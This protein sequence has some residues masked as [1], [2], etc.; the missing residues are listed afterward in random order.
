MKKSFL[1][2]LAFL[3]MLSANAQDKEVKYSY[4]F[5]TAINHE[6]PATST[7]SSYGTQ[8]N[9]LELNGVGNAKTTLYAYTDGTYKI[10]AWCGVEGYDLDFTLAEDSTITV[11]NENAEYKESKGYWKVPTGLETYDRIQIFAKKENTDGGLRSKICVSETQAT[12]T[13]RYNSYVWEKGNT[14]NASVMAAYYGRG[15][16][17]TPTK[18]AISENEWSDEANNYVETY[19][20]NTQN[21]STVDVYT[22]GENKY[23]AKDWL[24]ENTGDLYFTVN[25]NDSL[26][27]D[28][29]ANLFADNGFWYYYNINLAS[30]GIDPIWG[31]KYNG[32]SFAIGLWYGTDASDADTYVY[33]Y[34][35]I[36]PITEGISDT[37]ATDNRSGATDNAVYNIAGQRIGNN[38][39][40]IAIKNGKKVILK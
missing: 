30:D 32:N 38:F 20:L 39:K 28:D 8:N 7:E 17:G 11:L 14:G 12:V 18:Y 36:E 29:I 19:D 6:Y 35:F 9:L 3:G 21:T 2:G 31:S 33:R 34:I 25:E 4:P 15:F 5:E 16:A 22:L 1:L 27:V 13:L 26:I 37:M 23:V 40:G 10:A 24:G